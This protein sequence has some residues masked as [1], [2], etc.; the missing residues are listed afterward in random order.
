MLY[1]TK[2]GVKSQ[3]TQGRCIHANHVSRVSIANALESEKLVF[4]FLS[5]SCGTSHIGT[6]QNRID[7]ISYSA[8]SKQLSV[9]S[10]LVEVGARTAS[11]ITVS[12]ASS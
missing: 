10:Q 8:S 5:W 2:T 9:V 3:S 12:F 4:C 7:K 6:Q 1:K 11:H